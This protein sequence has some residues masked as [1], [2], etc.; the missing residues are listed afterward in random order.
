MT[1]KATHLQVAAIRELKVKRGPDGVSTFRAFF[2]YVDDSGMSHGAVSHE[3]VLLGVTDNPNTKAL[4][5]A[6][7][8]FLQALEDA[9]HVLHFNTPPRGQPAQMREADLPTKTRSLSEVLSAYDD[10]NDHG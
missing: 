7:A 2:S 4:E 10:P 6:A 9:A 3:F 1:F 8:A 5:E